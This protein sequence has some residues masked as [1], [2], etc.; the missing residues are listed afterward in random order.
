MTFAALRSMREAAA[1]DELGNELAR[2]LAEPVED[3]SEQ[4]A[5]IDALL[6]RCEQQPQHE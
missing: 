2:A 4:L 5:R 6:D 1:M 3:P